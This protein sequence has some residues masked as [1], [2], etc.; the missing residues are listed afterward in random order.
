MSSPFVPVYRQFP[1]EDPHNLEKQLVNSFTQSSTAINNRTISTFQTNAIANGERWFP[2]T[3]QQR[4]RDGNRIAVQVDDSNL[5]LPHGISLINQSTRLYGSF[6]DAS[7]NWQTLPYVDVTD[8]TNQI[9]ISV[10]STDIVVTKGAGSPPSISNG[11]VV[12]EYL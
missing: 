4:L 8:V 2:I 9:S 1:V 6:Q 10:T 7:G 11:I 5:T 12:F 3:G